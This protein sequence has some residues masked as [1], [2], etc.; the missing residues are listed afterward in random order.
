[1]LPFSNR[2]VLYP[3]KHITIPGLGDFRLKQP[4]P[5]ICSSQTFTISKTGDKWYVSFTMEADKVPPIIHEVES[6]GIDLGVKCFATLSSG[7][8]IVA[9]PSLKQAKIGAGHW[10]LVIGHWSLFANGQWL[11]ANC[12]KRQCQLAISN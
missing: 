9:P 8:R 10:S 1:M 12:K 2:Q 6:V 11:M 7:N 3:G 4:I 5:F